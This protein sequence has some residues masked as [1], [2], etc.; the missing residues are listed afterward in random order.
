MPP[1]LFPVAIG[2]IISWASFDAFSIFYFV[3]V[4]IGVTI[5]HIAL[6]MTDDYFDYKHA[7]DNTRPGEQN[8]YNGVSKTLTTGLIH[9]RNMFTVFILLYVIV[10]SLGLYLSVERGIFVLVF[11]L[12]GVFCS[13]FYTFPPVKFAYH[14]LGEIGL[15]LNFGPI[16]GLGAFYVQAQQLSIEAFLATLPCGIMLFSMII[17]NEIPDVEEDQLVGKLTL[18]ARFGT[19]T[20]LNLYI[21]SW[22]ATYTIILISVLFSY[23]SWPVL[24]CFISVPLSIDSI[25]ILRKQYNQPT[26]LVPANKRMIQAHALTSIGII[27]GYIWFGYIQGQKMFEMYLFIILL[28]AIYFP[29]LL[30]PLQVKPIK[31]K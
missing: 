20:G 21:I 16:L 1:S 7:V 30:P 28:L 18:V 10:I 25:I 29:A 17:I 8:P 15:L 6:N 27:V 24:I 13:V 3:L 11:G 12:I 14:G 26:L 19:K 31:T 23:L 22:I 9:P 5:N 2:S 4:L